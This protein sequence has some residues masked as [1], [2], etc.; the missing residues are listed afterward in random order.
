MARKSLVDQLLEDFAE[1][2]GISQEEIK[3]EPDYET[4]PLYEEPTESEEFD[5]E[6]PDGNQ[7]DEYFDVLFDSIDVDP[8]EETDQYSED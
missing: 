3:N 5:L 4:F 6:N 8:D 2:S 1:L 7:T